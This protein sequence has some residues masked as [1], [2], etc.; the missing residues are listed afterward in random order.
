MAVEADIVV[1]ADHLHREPRREQGGEEVEEDRPDGTGRAHDGVFRV[2]RHEH[3]AGA[4]TIRDRA[5][6]FGHR[7]SVRL[8]EAHSLSEMVAQPDVQVRDDERTGA[9]VSVRKDQRR[10]TEHRTRRGA[11]API[12]LGAMG[13]ARG[14]H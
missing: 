4:L 5:D 14:A 1:P 2:A 13:P 10:M 12:D 9:T 3:N 7:A 8:G 11:S 6:L